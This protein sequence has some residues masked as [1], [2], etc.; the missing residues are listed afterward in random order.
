M[1]GSVLVV[2]YSRSGTTRAVAEAL[3]KALDCGTE[4]ISEKKGRAGWRG[5]LRSLIDG[6][7][8]RPSLTAQWRLDPTAYDL[9]VI[10][11]PV[12]AWSLSSPVHAY[13]N[14]YRGRLRAVGFFCTQEATGSDSVFA[15][16]AKILGRSPRAVCALTSAEV[17]SSSFGPQLAAFVAALQE[18]AA[19]AKA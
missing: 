9:V 6:L 17:A 14:A 10:G 19:T 2:Y 3:T 11:T 8:Q 16:M 13:L 7:E 18:G 1:A 4:E 15:Q 5:Y 12:W